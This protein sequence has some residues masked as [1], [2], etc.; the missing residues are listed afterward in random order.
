MRPAVAVLR[1]QG[2]N[3]QVETAACLRARRLRAAR[4]AH[5][6]SARRAAYA[7]RSS[8]GSSPAAASPTATCW[9][10][11]RAG[12]SPSCSTR[13]CARSSQRFFERSDTFTLGICN[14][15]QM[16]AAL[17]ELIPGTEHW[18]RF[19][20]NR[21]EQYES[22][23]SM[24]EI[25]RLAVGG[26]ATAWRARSCRSPWR[27]ARAARSSHRTPR[28]SACAPSG[29]VGVPLRE[30]RPH[31]SR[32]LIPHNP[33]RLAVRHRGDL[34]TRTAASPSRC[35]TRSARSATCRIPG[36]RMA[37]GMERLDAAVPER[38]AVRGLRVASLRSGRA[39]GHAIGSAGWSLVDWG[40]WGR[41]ASRYY[42]ISGAG[43]KT[44]FHERWLMHS[45]P[46]LAACERDKPR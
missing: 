32:R 44:G 2:V 6:R 43:T 27:T 34:P 41:R 5:D 35:R 19:V 38:A 33:E 8:R 4:R 45:L 16:F 3:S 31:A 30:S 37:R 40:A 26:A 46:G 7:R 39:V 11:A 36:G 25:L 15:C 22:R 13:A 42:A 23:F 28:R 29:L 21:S 20:R 18:P 12:R 9:A 17:K 14:G 10:R 24:V 1:E